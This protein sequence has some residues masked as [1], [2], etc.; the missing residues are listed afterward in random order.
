MSSRL[1]IVRNEPASDDA[2]LNACNNCSYATYFHT[3]HWA[4]V[5]ASYTH[6][7]TSPSPRLITFSDNKTAIVP[8]SY[9]KHAGGLI[10]TWL[11]SPAGTFGGWISGDHLTSGHTQLLIDYML[12]FSNIVWRENPYD[13]VLQELVIPKATNDFT[14][15]VSLRLRS[16]ADILASASR[17]HHKAVKKAEQAGVVVTQAHSITD[18]EQ[19][20]T[21][22]Q[23]SM[24]RWNKAGTT[25]KRVKP[26]TWDIFRLM[27]ELPPE[28]RILWLAQCNGDVAAS[29]LCFYWNNH[30]VAW[31][32]AAH[33]EYFAIRPNNLLYQSMIQDAHI[34]GFHWFDCN[35]AGGLKGVVEFKDHLGTQRIQSRMVDKSG[36]IKTLYRMLPR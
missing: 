21:A 18:W 14:Q 10:K 11:S 34:R 32:G 2:W 25:K 17:A 8:L 13:T 6:G 33:E 22:Y 3:P 27:Y 36:V 29:V 16:W 20:Y 31:H 12:S 28:Q 30:A 5:F 26:Y 1:T 9:S 7:A 23:S 24:E 19:H 15:T 4:H 35:P